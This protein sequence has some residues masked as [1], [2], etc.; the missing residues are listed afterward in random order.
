MG[1]PTPPGDPSGSRGKTQYFVQPSPSGGEEA[2]AEV[3][4]RWDLQIPQPRPSEASHEL[5]PGKLLVSDLGEAFAL[6]G[7][8]GEGGMGFVLKAVAV[9]SA[10]NAGFLPTALLDGLPTAPGVYDW[11]TVEM[12]ADVEIRQPSLPFVA[13]KILGMVPG[14]PGFKEG[15]ARFDR[16][17][18]LLARGFDPSFPPFKGKGNHPY[19]HIVMECLSG[20]TLGGILDAAQITDYHLPSGS[21][22]WRH[23]FSWAHLLAKALD[24][25]HRAGIIHRDL[26][27]DNVWIAELPGFAWP[28]FLDLGLAYEKPSSQARIKG[29]RV[30]HAFRTQGIKGS[31]AYMSPEHVVTPDDVDAPADCLALGCMITEM[32]AG[33]HL[34][35]HITS[36]A[37]VV[38]R[39]VPKVC[40]PELSDALNRDLNQLIESACQ[41]DARQRPTARAIALQLFALEHRRQSA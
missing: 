14:T 29:E 10:C 1:N 9:R 30:T 24:R 15:V 20:R 3:A 13:L 27:P 2:P 33:K 32:V 21:L 7:V 8:L 40:H 16:E 28:M 4:A 19:H 18:R 12:L 36:A 37:Q 31:C 11:M 34:F 23:I 38:K 6:W 26:K 35:A 41:Y 5:A 17:A 39:R 22:K 25:M